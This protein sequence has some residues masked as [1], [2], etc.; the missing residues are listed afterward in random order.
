MY[1]SVVREVI[2]NKVKQYEA[3]ESDTL[4]P[5]HI[6]VKARKLKRDCVHMEWVET[7]DSHQFGRKHPACSSPDII[8]EYVSDK[9]MITSCLD[10]PFYRE[11]T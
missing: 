11:D 4:A 7:R 10:C 6:S 1:S 2:E 3:L 9:A 8:K 5:F